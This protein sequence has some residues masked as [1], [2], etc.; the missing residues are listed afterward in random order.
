MEFRSLDNLVCVWGGVVVVGKR[1]RALF[2]TVFILIPFL[3]LSFSES[4][5]YVLNFLFGASTAFD[6]V[7]I[8]LLMY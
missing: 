8:L 7:P 3:S 1:S 4:G 2:S 5:R 6:L